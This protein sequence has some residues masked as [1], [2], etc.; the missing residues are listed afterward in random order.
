MSLA[1][2]TLLVADSFDGHHASW[3][4]GWMWVWGSL[5]LLVFAVLA[6]AAVWLLAG[7]RRTNDS[8]RPP[9]TRD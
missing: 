6:G 3:D 4:G 5:M 7:T 1:G 8:A 2:L 9:R